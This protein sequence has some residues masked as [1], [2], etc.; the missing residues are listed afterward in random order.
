[1]SVTSMIMLWQLAINPFI[2][3]IAGG[4]IAI[5]L[6]LSLFYIVRYFF[7]REVQP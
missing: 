5:T 3:E 6:I 2:D 1:M 4:V 7:R